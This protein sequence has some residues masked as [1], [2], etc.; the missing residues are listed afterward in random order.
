MSF[1]K[2]HSLTLGKKNHYILLSYY[3]PGG[4]WYLLGVQSLMGLC[5]MT[6]GLVVTMALLWIIDKILP[7]RMDPYTELMGADITEH[8]I[9]HGQVCYFFKSI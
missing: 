7:I 3:S 8:R 2:N 4:G 9:R 1:V 6:W 5:L